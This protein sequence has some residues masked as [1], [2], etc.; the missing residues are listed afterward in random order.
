MKFW[1]GYVWL[2]WWGMNGGLALR[3]AWSHK[4]VEWSQLEGAALSCAILAGVPLLIWMAY[5]TR[6][7]LSGKT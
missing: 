1:L 2:Y 6:R 3:S 4:A 7:S 5:H